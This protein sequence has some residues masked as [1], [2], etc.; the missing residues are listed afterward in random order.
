MGRRGEWGTAGVTV[1]DSIL[2]MIVSA[3]P[4]TWSREIQF[5][6]CYEHILNSLRGDAIFIKIRLNMS[7]HHLLALSGVIPKAGGESSSLREMAT[8]GYLLSFAGQSA[9]AVEKQ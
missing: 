9:I 3:L 4:C 6:N 7:V 2:C 5:F 8:D 1:R